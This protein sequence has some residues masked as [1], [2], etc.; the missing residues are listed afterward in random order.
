[1]R[2]ITLDSFTCTF[3]LSSFV[4]IF[5][6]L[7]SFVAT[8]YS[9]SFHSPSFICSYI[10]FLTCYCETFAIFSS[11][12]SFLTYM[13][14]SA[15]FS[16]SLLPSLPPLNACVLLSSLQTNPIHRFYAAITLHTVA[17][18]SRLTLCLTLITFNRLYHV[19]LCNTSLPFVTSFHFSCITSIILL[20]L[21]LLLLLFLLLLLLSLLL[22]LLIS[23]PF[24]HLTS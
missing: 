18:K 11:L 6:F 20:S 10:L 5:L 16:F 24:F 19:I 12:P 4:L 2:G 8:S 15:Q 9:L 22:L 3:F 14:L 21:L 13:L 17:F 7:C 1:M 23:Y